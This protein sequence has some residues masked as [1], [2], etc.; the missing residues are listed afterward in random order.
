MRAKKNCLC[1]I[2]ILRL[3]MAALCLL[4]CAVTLSASAG[5]YDDGGMLRLVNRDE[6]LSK[7]YKPED[8][9]LPDVPTNKASQKE[10]IYMRPDAASALEAL[11]AAAAEEEGFE[12]LAVSGYR[13]YSTQYQLFKRKVESVGSRERAQKTVA[14]AGASEHQ[15]GLAMDVVSVNFRYLNKDFLETPEGK[16][17]NDNCWRFGFIVRYRAEWT[18]ETGCNAEPWHIRYLG[19]AHAEAVTRLY[20]P[21]E[22]YAAC[23]RQLPDY[24]L[25][26]ADANL[27]TALIGD[28][29][30]GDFEMA[31]VAQNSSTATAKAGRALLAELTAY[32]A[33]GAAGEE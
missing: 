26:N 7:D 13:A 29:L 21:Y 1:T 12:L 23:A 2:D 19:P 27:L 24:V 33:A 31:E 16:W 20:V 18:E 28:M 10:S 9:V 14:P 25:E 6:K 4:L 11:F 15:L 30:Q 8:L 3:V 22:T 5:P 32:Y 17:V